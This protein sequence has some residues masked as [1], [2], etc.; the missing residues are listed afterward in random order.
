MERHLA[1]RDEVRVLGGAAAGTD[2]PRP[3][4]EGQE[5][6]DDE[7]RRGGEEQLRRHG[8]PSG[9]SSPRATRKA[10]PDPEPMIVSPTS[11]R[12]SSAGFAS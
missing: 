8:R 7:G 6:P 1:A 10:S 5:D 11:S 9:P 4:R 2:V 12:R 3:Q